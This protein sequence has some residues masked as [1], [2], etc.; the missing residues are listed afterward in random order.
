MSLRRWLA[1]QWPYLL[2]AAGMGGV[3]WVAIATRPGLG[4]ATLFVPPPLASSRVAW[5][6]IDGSPV[7]LVKGRRYRGCVQVPWVVPTGLVVGKLP[8]GLADKGFTD[9]RVSRPRPS[10]WPDVSCDIHVEATW[11]KDDESMDRP[12]AVSL[13]WR[14]DRAVA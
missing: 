9:V 8:Q 10:D 6:L 4:P 1:A 5:L 7:R 3:V 12:G 13:A 11:G 14:G 2:G